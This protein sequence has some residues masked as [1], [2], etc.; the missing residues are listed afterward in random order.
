MREAI[1]LLFAVQIVPVQ[2]PS[3]LGEHIKYYNFNKFYACLL[4][5]LFS[6]ETDIP[7]VGFRFVSAS[8]YH[9]FNRKQI[10]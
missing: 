6:C 3:I 10:Q 1:K 7:Q 2:A 9:M 4:T 8:A 5:K